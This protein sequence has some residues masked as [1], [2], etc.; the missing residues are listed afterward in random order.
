MGNPQP[1]VNTSEN[2]WEELRGSQQVSQKLLGKAP[3]QSAGVLP[4]ASVHLG[5]IP[6]HGEIPSIMGLNRALLEKQTAPPHLVGL[7]K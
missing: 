3:L 5:A 7:I 1:P 6:V 4:L 2:V